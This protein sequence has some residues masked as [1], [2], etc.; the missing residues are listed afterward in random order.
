MIDPNFGSVPV[1]YLALIRANRNF[2]NLWLGQLVSN[3]GDWFNL[4][5]TT[6]LVAKLTESGL[7][8]GLLFMIRTLAP[9]L[10]APIGGVIADRYNRRKIIL[11]TNLLRAPTIL[12]FLLVRDAGDVWL[13]YLLTGIQLF[14]GGIFF[15]ARSAMLPDIVSHRAIGAANA[16]TGATFAAMLAI[17]SA[18][19]GFFSGLVGIYPAFVINGLLYLFSVFF[20]T[21][22][23]LEKPESFNDVD[24]SVFNVFGEYLD[25][26]RYMATHSYLLVIAPHKAFMGL[27]LGSTFEVVQVTIAQTVFVI[28]DGGG[29][30]MGLMFAFSGFGLLF[31]TLIIKRFVND[32]GPQLVW[33]ITVGYLVG[34]AGIALTALLANLGLT[35]VG[36]FLRGMGNGIVW[37]FST[38]LILQLVPTRVRGRVVA[39]EFALNMVVSAGGAA[40]VGKAL[41][42]AVGISGVAWVMAGMTL[43]PAILWSLWILAGGQAAIARQ[44]EIQEARAG[45]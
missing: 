41:D 29:S 22:I 42:S 45:I 20:I 36:T 28:G 43:L 1:G 40:I 38:Q 32:Q 12:S 3:L 2:R 19:G 13:L 6:S 15:P 11:I 10:A 25:G 21:K 4:I 37:L 26:L 16:I 24:R 27:L 8:I 5:A 14:I 33:A 18:L 39:T 30:S 34:G 17:G 35:L 44:V 9:F 23:Q 7:A 31:S